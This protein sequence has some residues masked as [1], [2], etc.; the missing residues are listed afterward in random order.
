MMDECTV[1]MDFLK[2]SFFV[3]ESY[4]FFNVPFEQTVLHVLQTSNVFQ[5]NHVDILCFLKEN[6]LL[7]VA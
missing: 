6:Q 2:N 1:Y 4:C 5:F 3:F 7:A